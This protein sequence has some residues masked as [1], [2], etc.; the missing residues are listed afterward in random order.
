MKYDTNTHKKAVSDFQNAFCRI[1][2][3]LTHSYRHGTR[4]AGEVAG[5]A[6]NNKCG[7]GVAYNARIGGNDCLMF[8]GVFKSSSSK[9][10]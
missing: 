2:L 3:I 1:H 10:P 9:V 6:N 8:I 5:Q 7:V 4:C